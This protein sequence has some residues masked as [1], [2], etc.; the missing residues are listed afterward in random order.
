MNTDADN[1]INN[2][3]AD[4]VYKSDKLDFSLLEEDMLSWFKAYPLLK[5]FTELPIM[6]SS[7]ERKKNQVKIQN[8]SDYKRTLPEGSPDVDSID[9]YINKFEA[10][11]KELNI[12]KELREQMSY[13]FK[14]P[15]N[16]LPEYYQEMQRLNA[17]ANAKKL[18]ALDPEGK[19]RDALL[20]RLNYLEGVSR[21]RCEEKKNLFYA[22]PNDITKQRIPLTEVQKDMTE[23]FVAY[24]SRINELQEKYD[25]KTLRDNGMNETD[26]KEAM[27]IMQSALDIV[28]GYEDPEFEELL[29]LRERERQREEAEMARKAKK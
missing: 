16:A 21:S 12:K 1:L 2:L 19:Y 22:P 7:L 3:V 18:V 28:R 14:N 29:Q 11:R 23:V 6:D 27:D 17:I 15:A 13:R 26:T 10:E 8:L 20:D 24:H 5:K 25:K 4:E 9:F